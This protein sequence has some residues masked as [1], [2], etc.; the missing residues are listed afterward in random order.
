MVEWKSKRHDF[1]IVNITVYHKFW[2]IW[3]KY[4]NTSGYSDQTLASS[5]ICPSFLWDVIE[6]KHLKTKSAKPN[7]LCLVCLLSEQADRDLF[8][9]TLTSRFSHSILW[10]SPYLKIFRNTQIIL[11]DTFYFPIRHQE[12]LSHVYCHALTG[13]ECLE[14]GMRKP[15]ADMFCTS[16]HAL[17]STFQSAFSKKL[18]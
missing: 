5:L 1:K 2:S 13:L 10:I 17:L 3:R 8:M 6:N 14:F 18:K 15:T 9:E 16:A 11:F 12:S 4:T 7:G